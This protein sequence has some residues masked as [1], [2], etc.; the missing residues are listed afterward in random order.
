MNLAESDRL[1]DALEDIWQEL[2]VDLGG[3]GL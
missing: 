2:G 1:S 3:L